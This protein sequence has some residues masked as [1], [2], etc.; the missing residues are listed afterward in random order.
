[1][2]DIR[3]EIVAFAQLMEA[4]MRKHDAKWGDSWKDMLPEQLALRF[5]EECAEMWTAARW[6]GEYC[7]LAAEEA[8][9]V[10]NVAMFIAWNLGTLSEKVRG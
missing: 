5:T 3:P 10:A 6:G 7:G 4:K 2:T 1:M 9:D 8:A